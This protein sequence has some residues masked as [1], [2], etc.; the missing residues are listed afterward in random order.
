MIPKGPSYRQDPPAAAMYDYLARTLGKD[1]GLT[2]YGAGERLIEWT[3][4]EGVRR[5]QARFA[6][7][8]T[9]RVAH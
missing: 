4:N 7:G 8:F 5:G 6:K 3:A 1:C 2:D 9:R